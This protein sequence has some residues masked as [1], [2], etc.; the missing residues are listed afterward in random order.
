MK[1]SGIH[2]SPAAAFLAYVRGLEMHRS[3]VLLQ[4]AHAR[5]CRREAMHK[6]QIDAV[7]RV[8]DNLDPRL[9]GEMREAF[10]QIRVKHYPAKVKVPA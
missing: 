7:L 1:D 2:D 3:L 9:A 6:E 4:K 5:Q 10:K 8:L